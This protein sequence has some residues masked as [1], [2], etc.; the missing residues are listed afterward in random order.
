VRGENGSLEFTVTQGHWRALENG[1]WQVTLDVAMKNLT[2]RDLQ[3]GSWYFALVVSQRQ[4]NVANCASTAQEE[5]VKPNRVGDARFGW[6]VRCK[7]DGSIELVVNDP[8]NGQ[9]RAPSTISVAV[10]SEPSDC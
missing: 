2:S 9:D 7:P 6:E 3:V 8:A 5:F 1:Q 4:F 10:A